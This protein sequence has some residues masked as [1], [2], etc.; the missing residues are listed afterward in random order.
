ML[1]S[2]DHQVVSRA[3]YQRQAP[4]P[5]QTPFA[6]GS[7]TSEKSNRHTPAPQLAT[8]IGAAYNPSD[9]VAYSTDPGFILNCEGQL[10]WLVN[11]QRQI[12]RHL[13]R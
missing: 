5:G 2:V 10:P 1:E 3:P 12:E 7:V 13:V 6:V 11:F 9:S 4:L 8:L